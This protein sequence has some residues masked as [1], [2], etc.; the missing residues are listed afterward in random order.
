MASSQKNPLLMQQS[1]F[2]CPGFHQQTCEVLA[3][4]DV[5]G[6]RIAARAGPGFSR[7]CYELVNASP[8]QASAPTQPVPGAKVPNCVARVVR[9]RRPPA[10]RWIKSEKEGAPAGAFRGFVEGLFERR[11]IRGTK[12]G[13]RFLPGR[14]GRIHS[15]VHRY[16]KQCDHGNDNRDGFLLHFAALEK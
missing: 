5:A 14:R 1:G 7:A 3:R 11:E 10:D 15:Q 16:K 13:E 9:P 4:R 8:S 2:G 12:R 6:P